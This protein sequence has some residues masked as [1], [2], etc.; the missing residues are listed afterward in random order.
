ML[1]KE[2]SAGRPLPTLAKWV[3]VLSAVG[4]ATF[5]VWILGNHYDPT[6][7]PLLGSLAKTTLGMFGFL[8]GLCVVFDRKFDP[9][10]RRGWLFL[11]LAIFFNMLGEALWMYYESY[12]GI[13]PFPSLADVFYLLYYP[14][15][16]GGLLLFPFAPA[17]P[18]ERRTLGLDLAIVMTFCAMFAWYFILAPLS[19]NAQPGWAGIIAL[20]YPVGD[21]L[22]L[23]GV[24]AL[25]QRD[26]LNVAR[27]ALFF[28]ACSLICTT[29]ADSLF[30]YFELNGQPY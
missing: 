27:G 24:V 8:F 19:Q 17:R 13:D 25:I 4:V 2:F 12:L 1:R 10:L 6:L 16:L 18:L 22:L 7:Q 28:L 29:S 15:M 5:A 11:S 9:R 30:L 21:L 20:A 26:V 23:A 14:L 3:L